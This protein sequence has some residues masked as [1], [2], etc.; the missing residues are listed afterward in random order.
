MIKSIISSP[1]TISRNFLL[2]CIITPKEGGLRIFVQKVY[3]VKVV[4]SLL[5]VLCELWELKSLECGKSAWSS[6]S[7]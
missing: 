4:D 2:V 3:I 5:R 7:K 1:P 6:N